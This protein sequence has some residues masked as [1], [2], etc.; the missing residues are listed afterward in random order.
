MTAL[1]EHCFGD[2]KWAGMVWIRLS[3]ANESS[4]NVSAAYCRSSGREHS[5]SDM[6]VP[7]TLVEP[8]L[9]NAT[10]ALSFVT[11]SN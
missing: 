9:G 4:L 10:A 11:R 7:E 1:I 5:S 3:S 6:S 8:S 2:V